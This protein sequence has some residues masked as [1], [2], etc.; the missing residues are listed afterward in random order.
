MLRLFIVI[1]C[2]PTGF[3]AW[4]RANDREG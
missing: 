2:H 3:I 4:T 1:L